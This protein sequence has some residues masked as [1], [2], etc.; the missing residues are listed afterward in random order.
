MTIGGADRIRTGDRGVAD[1]CL[2]AW[3]LRQIHFLT[4]TIL[5]VH[6]HEMMT[7]KRHEMI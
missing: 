7:K 6:H 5:Y 3:L 1:Q 2:S 4:Y